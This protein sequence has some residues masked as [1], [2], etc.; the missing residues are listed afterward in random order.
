[1]MHK[2]TYYQSLK[3]IFAESPHGFLNTQLKS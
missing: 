2:K 1:M 3:S